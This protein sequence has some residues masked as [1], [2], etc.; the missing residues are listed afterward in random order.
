MAMNSR[1]NSILRR[2]RRKFW[3]LHGGEFSR[4][5]DTTEAPLGWQEAPL[6]WQEAPLGGQEA[7]HTYFAPWRMPLP[8]LAGALRVQ[9]VQKVQQFLVSVVRARIVRQAMCVGGSPPYGLLVSI[10]STDC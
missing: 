8:R 7:A 5:F 9:K 3:R 4:E 2:L 10:L 6:W 1:E